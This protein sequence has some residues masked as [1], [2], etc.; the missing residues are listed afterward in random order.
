MSTLGAN[1]LSIHDV[2][3]RSGPNGEYQA[4]AE[5]L[6]EIN[7]LAT[8]APW[9]QGELPA[10]H[11]NTVRDSL[12][13]FS[14]RQPNS[15]GITPSK[16]TTSQTLE[17]PEYIEAWS[18]TDELVLKYGGDSANA[19]AS[20]MPAFSEAAMQTVSDRIIYGNGATTVGQVN[21]LAVRYNSTSA[22]NGRN[23]ILGGAVGGQTD[24]MSIY[25][26]EYG[27]G[28]FSLW[29]PKGSTGGL[30]VKDWGERPVSVSGATIVRRQ[31]QFQWG[32]G[33]AVDD[34][35][36]VVRI[37]NI[38]KSLLIAGTGADLPFRLNQATHCLPRNVSTGRRAFYMNRT[39]FLYLDDQC[40]ND[41]QTGGQL[42]YEKVE[43]QEMH[44]WRGIPIN[45]FDTLTEAETAIS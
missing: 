28:K 36:R 3:R 2:V 26:C 15:S 37:A 14:T 42:K 27:T 16:S 5:M 38:D 32:F 21:G 12:P 17:A 13:T 1:N 10:G 30:M 20:E 9:I 45:I 43:G 29:Y 4:I 44:T 19:I 40:R 22:T 41:V 7:T 33:L 18:D 11:M 39:T 6:Q 31:V 34:W 35:R 23:V 24:C 8:D 25:L